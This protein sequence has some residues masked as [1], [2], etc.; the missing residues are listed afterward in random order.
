MRHTVTSCQWPCNGPYVANYPQPDGVFDSGKL[1]NFDPIDGGG[2]TTEGGP[3][4]G[5]GLSE[6]TRP[7][8]DLDTSG[9]EPGLY[10]FYCRVHPWM[11]GS[12]E[13]V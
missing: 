7:V 10:S 12:L 9:L 4:M 11:R 2:V 6:E 8:Y 3:L 5:Y 1:G 13:V